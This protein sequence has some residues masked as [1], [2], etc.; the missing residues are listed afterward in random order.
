MPEQEKMNLLHEIG[1]GQPDKRP[2]VF[3]GNIPADIT[4][5]KE[6]SALNRINNPLKSTLYLG[7]PN[8]IRPA[9]SLSIEPM[10]GQNILL[11]GQQEESALSLLTSTLI[12]LTLQ[13]S[14]E[15]CEFVIFDGSSADLPR[16]DYFQTLSEGF[17]HSISVIKPNK[18]TDSISQIYKQLQNRLE[19]PSSK[20]IILLFHGLQRFRKLKQDDSFSWDD[21][22]KGA[23][24]QLGEILA[25]GS[26][27]SIHSFLWCDSW[28]SFTRI[29]PRKALN[30]FEYRILFQ[31]S[32]A[33]SVNLIDS[34]QASHL[35]MNTALFFNDQSGDALKFRPFALPATSWIKGLKEASISQ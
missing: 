20:K 6:L 1:A 29:M 4:L 24:A 9:Q 21:D 8:A 2:F 5:C 3:E 23:G 31:M 34:P 27:N 16:D 11:I 25:D 14:A 30:S 35:G 32:P 12:S 19:E 28:N 10:A 18:S 22:D 26:E 33:D 17:D 13:Y 7:E 15:N